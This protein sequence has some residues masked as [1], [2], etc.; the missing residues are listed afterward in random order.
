MKVSI[1]S[2]IKDGP[3][4]GG[5]LFVK[6]LKTHLL[7]KNHKVVHDLGDNDIDLIFMTEPRKT[8]ESSAFTAREVHDYLKFKKQDAMVVHRINECD[9]RKGTKHVNQQIMDANKVSD[10][11]IFVSNW[12]KNLY[13]S[14]GFVFGHNQVIMSGSNTEVFNTEDFKPWKKNEP[15]RIVT[16]HWGNNWNKGFSI[17][18]RLDQLIGKKTF[19]Y[20][21][22]FT[23]IGKLPSKFSFKFSKYITP[24]EGK[25]LAKEIKNNNLYLT[26]SINE[27]SG[28]HHIE[29]GLCGLPILYL[30]SG[31][32][33]EYCADFGVSFSSE[34][35][36]Q[37]LKKIID[38]YD[39]FYNKMKSYNRT[40]EIMCQAY[41]DVFEN[42][43]LRKQNIINKRKLD[44]SFSKK[45][46]MIFNLKE[47][48]KA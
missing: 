47:K 32:I 44:L 5:N 1:G 16:H 29:G 27:P 12:L 9:E 10:Y 6:N 20:D 45:E 26:A 35:F 37:K 13:L 34:N 23:Y 28:N 11:T 17:Y 7:S 36:E 25:D 24:L 2:I 39:I 43:V 18:E 31:G 3:W 4:G 21:L 40:S 14:N 41:E 22:E 30:D 38:E 46:R 15:V 19:P 8:S 42:L 48:F 33:T